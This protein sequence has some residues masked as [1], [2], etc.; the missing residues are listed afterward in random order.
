MSHELRTPLNAIIGYSE[1]LLDGA[2]AEERKED[3]TDHERILT[4]A[5]HLLALINDLLDLSRIEASKMETHPTT[6]DVNALCEQLLDTMRPMAKANANTLHFMSDG[7][8]GEAFSDERL[9]KQCL[10][11]LMS[12]ACKFTEDGRVSLRAERRG[13]MFVFHV[14]DTGIG[15]T[16]EQQARL[17]NPFTQAAPDTRERFGGTGLGL[18]LTRELAHLLGGEVNVVSAPGQGS[19]FTLRVATALTAHQ[20]VAEAAAAA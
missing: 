1:L 14:H 19:I 12:N 6:F 9:L 16:E 7:T 4:A 15:L 10:L 20:P 2:Q 18:A 5:K 17:F 13:A 3:V 11:N 8:L